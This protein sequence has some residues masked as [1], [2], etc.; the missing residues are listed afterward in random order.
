MSAVPSSPATAWLFAA[1]ALVLVCA[2]AL[3]AD[4][5]FAEVPRIPMQF[6]LDGTVNWTAPRRLGLAFAP[7]LGAIVLISVL[8]ARGHGGDAQAVVRQVALTGAVLVAAEL[9]HIVLLVRH[10]AAR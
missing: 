8:L 3:W 10:F 2:I 6:G 4:R 7:A 9:F 1:G 5:R